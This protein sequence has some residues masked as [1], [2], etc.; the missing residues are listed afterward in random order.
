MEGLKH[1]GDGDLEQRNVTQSANDSTS[2]NITPSIDSDDDKPKNSSSKLE[3]QHSAEATAENVDT[4][5]AQ[6]VAKDNEFDQD[7]E[8]T[9]AT[10]TDKEVFLYCKRNQ[11]SHGSLI[12]FKMT[13]CPLCSANLEPPTPATDVTDQAEEVD[14]ADTIHPPEQEARI[15]HTMVIKDRTG[16]FVSSD[17]YD[18][19]ACNPLKRSADESFDR[20]LVLET[21]ASVCGNF[22]SRDFSYYGTSG[23]KSLL[24]NSRYSYIYRGTDLKIHSKYIIDAINVVAPFL[25]QIGEFVPHTLAEPYAVVGYHLQALKDYAATANIE[26]VS[27]ST[28][29]GPRCSK[30]AADHLNI[31]LDWFANSGHETKIR[32]E[33]QR[34]GKGLCTFR[35]LWLALRPGMTV[36][37]VSDGIVRAYVIESITAST[38]GY[39]GTECAVLNSEITDTMKYTIKLWNLRYDNKFVGRQF[40]DVI[41]A[42]FEGEKPLRSL[43]VIPIDFYDEEI[44]G[45]MKARLEECGRFW[46]KSL[47]GKQVAYKGTSMQTP[48]KQ[49][50]LKIL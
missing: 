49:A 18:G 48:N 6:V 32:E 39:A 31:L 9:E 50:C 12:S 20:R 4:D 24:E 33:E 1:S 40:T 22:S 43:T 8:K 42:H 41:I 44:P 27:M 38:S 10:S 13:M 11:Q 45:T 7:L 14:Q 26:D 23:G 28:T 36:Y 37:M 15:K 47:C 25:H 17:P 46:Y 21:I 29:K 2:D 35:M 19:D 30:T 34:H 3:V 5:D 16:E